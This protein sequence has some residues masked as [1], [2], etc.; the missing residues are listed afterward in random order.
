[1]RKKPRTTRDFEN[2]IISL[3]HTFENLTRLI[4]PTNQLID[5]PR[6]SGLQLVLAGALGLRLTAFLKSVQSNLSDWIRLYLR[7]VYETAQHK[8]NAIM[9]TIMVRS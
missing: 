8:Y 1:M 9:K 3:Q 7:H 2:R 4:N 5:A 6:S